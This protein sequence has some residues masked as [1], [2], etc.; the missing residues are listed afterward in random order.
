[1]NTVETRKWMFG[2]LQGP[3]RIGTESVL[4][5]EYRSGAECR[6]VNFH[7]PEDAFV[8]VANN[9]TADGP[10]FLLR[11]LIA[12]F[13]SDSHQTGWDPRDVTFDKARVAELYR[14]YE[15]ESLQDLEDSQARR[16]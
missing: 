13:M 15:R 8:E 4:S 5:A 14:A 6:T 9:A 1:M 2:E 12:I 7:V 3:R 11:K 16:Y 10:D